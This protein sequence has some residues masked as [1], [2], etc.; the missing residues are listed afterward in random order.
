MSSSKIVFADQ[1][2][3]AEFEKE[4]GPPL[5]RRIPVPRD[6]FCLR[7]KKKPGCG[8]AISGVL[9]MGGDRPVGRRVSVDSPRP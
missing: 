5:S 8:S 4:A 1:T 9:G 7:Y 3:A 6:R 2:V